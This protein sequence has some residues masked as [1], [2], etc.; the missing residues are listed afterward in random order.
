MLNGLGSGGPRIGLR[1]IGYLLY[2][3]VSAQ[4]L[5]VLAFWHARR[6]AGPD[7]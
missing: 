7:L 3:R 5:E 1:R 4:R 2:Y 6:G